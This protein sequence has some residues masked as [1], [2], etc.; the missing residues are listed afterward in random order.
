MT[1]FRW[2]KLIH[3]CILPTKKWI[4]DAL[5]DFNQ[6]VGS[7]E[8]Q[9]S[10]SKNKEKNHNFSLETVIFNANCLAVLTSCLLITKTRPCN[11]L[12][13]FTAVKITIFG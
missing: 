9:K 4:V 2:K 10:M 13:Y 5:L 6:G 8:Y 12:Q 3:D 11:I 7:K 1:I